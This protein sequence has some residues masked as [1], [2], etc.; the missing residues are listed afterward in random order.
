MALVVLIL[1]GASAINYAENA[2]RYSEIAKILVAEQD[3]AIGGMW[4]G[5]GVGDKS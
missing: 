5:L 2:K 4:Q 1:V 3:K